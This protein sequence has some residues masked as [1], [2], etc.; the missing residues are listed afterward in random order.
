MWPPEYFTDQ[1]RAENFQFANDSKIMK[2]S[3]FWLRKIFCSPLLKFWRRPKNLKL[4]R[5]PWGTFSNMQIFTVYRHFDDVIS[6]FSGRHNF[7][8][9]WAKL[10]EN[11]LV[12]LVNIGV[13]KCL[14]FAML[15]K[16]LPSGRFAH[17]FYVPLGIKYVYG[18]RVD[19][20]MGC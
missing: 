10:S 6:Q 19:K 16:E 7:W 8:R 11:W 2:N 4:I 14:S 20:Y 3:L 18:R 9:E 5:C 12:N 13:Y 15:E 1:K 17:L